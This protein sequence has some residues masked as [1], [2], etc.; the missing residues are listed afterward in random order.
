MEV[1]AAAAAIALMAVPF[2]FAGVAG[3]AGVIAI[4]VRPLGVRE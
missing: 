1:V 3:F 2:V 4:A